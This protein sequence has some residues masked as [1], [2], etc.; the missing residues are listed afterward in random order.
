MLISK[1]CYF[2]L[3]RKRKPQGRGTPKRRREATTSKKGAPRP[4]KEWYHRG[5]EMGAARNASS[6]RGRGTEKRTTGT[7]AGSRNR[8]RNQQPTRNG[9]KEKKE[10][11]SQRWMKNKQ[12]SK[13][14]RW[15]RKRRNHNT[16]EQTKHNL[17][18][19]STTNLTTM[20]V[21]TYLVVGGSRWMWRPTLQIHHRRHFRS[22][23][24]CWK[25]I[26]EFWRLSAA[27][28]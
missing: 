28:N 7:E 15:W 3:P 1:K 12:Q 9:V 21:A 25:R 8:G 16:K 2:K 17:E 13:Q 4:R 26:S 5:Q 14:W 23:G 18:N 20:V 19:K 22:C 10:W 6:H 11:V 27:R 24:S